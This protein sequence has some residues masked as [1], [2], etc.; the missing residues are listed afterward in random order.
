MLAGGKTCFIN[1]IVHVVIEESRKLRV[2]CFKILRKKVDLLIG[3]R[4]EGVIEHAAEVILGVIDDLLA[5][6][7]PENR[8]RYPA[9]VAGIRS[10]ISLR[11]EGKA[12]ER[13]GA[14][15]RT[16]AKGTATLV[17]NWISYSDAYRRLK[18]L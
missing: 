9:M 3:K 13:I 4:R 15:T 17:P 1:A 6:L 7:V 11:K 5:L 8:D 18:L 14:V 10:R 2:L 16:I 12:I